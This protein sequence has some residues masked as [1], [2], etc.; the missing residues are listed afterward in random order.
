[1]VKSL[2]TFCHN[3]G[4]ISDHSK[5]KNPWVGHTMSQDY[6]AHDVVSLERG[7]SWL[8]FSS[9]LMPMNMDAWNIISKNSPITD[10]NNV[11]KNTSLLVNM[12]YDNNDGS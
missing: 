1:M 9:N 12:N 5:K 4:E 8:N 11:K 10:Y 7:Y 6:A 3:V 2:K